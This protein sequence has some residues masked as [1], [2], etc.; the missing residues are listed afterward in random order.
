MKILI[1]IGHPAHVHLFKN[2]IIQWKKN[3]DEVLVV[4]REKD[5]TLE[6][7]DYYGIQYMIGSSTGGGSRM[8]LKGLVQHT[9]RIIRKAMETNPDTVLGVGSPMAAWASWILKVPY[10]AFDDTERAAIE[11]LLYRP[12][13]KVVYT[14]SCFLDDFKK[15]R[16]Y[17]GYHELAYLHPNWFTPDPSVLRRLGL[18][19]DEPF[20]IIRFVA[21]R[22]AHDIGQKGFTDDDKHQII[23]LLQKH[24]KVILSDENTISTNLVGEKISIKPQDIH[25]LLYYAAMYIGEGGTMAT[26]AALLGT[27]SVFVSTLSGGNWEELEHKYRLMFSLHGEQVKEQVRALLRT[28]NIKNQWQN[29]RADL[30]KEKIDVTKF[31]MAEVEKNVKERE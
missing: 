11:H 18:E 31:I 6:L 17:D 5:V 1:D 15:Q 29:K 16:R 9:V 14:P 22:A 7:L 23:A 8:N 12:F 13:A 28:K 21:W 10:I 4:A 27:P 19:V 2:A 30:L 24:G 26:E 20:F 25:S 3:G